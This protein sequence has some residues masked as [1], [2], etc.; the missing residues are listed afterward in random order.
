M[1]AKIHKLFQAIFVMLFCIC[2]TGPPARRTNPDIFSR[3]QRNGGGVVEDG[4]DIETMELELDDA[5]SPIATGE[6]RDGKT[7]VLLQYAN[8]LHLFS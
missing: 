2:R 7:I 8:L 6:I 5:L 4:E 3:K 1:V